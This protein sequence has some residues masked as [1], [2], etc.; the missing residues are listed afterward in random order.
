MAVWRAR[1]GE[2]S[3]CWPPEGSCCSIVALRLA[4]ILAGGAVLDSLALACRPLLSA[5][6]PR[7]LPPIA[8]TGAFTASRMLRSSRLWASLLWQC[9]S[10]DPSRTTA[11]HSLSLN[12][13]DMF[14]LVPQ[15]KR[16]AT[17]NKGEHPSY[18]LAPV[19]PDVAI[20]SFVGQIVAAVPFWTGCNACVPLMLNCIVL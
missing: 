1:K 16:S 8:P 7:M 4:H 10:S 17:S 20:L 6:A 9:H 15:L 19:L 2:H 11:F 12:Q 14:I 13:L 3:F 18:R 5:H